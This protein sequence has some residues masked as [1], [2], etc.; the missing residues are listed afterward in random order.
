MNHEEPSPT[1]PVSPDI[2][3][4]FIAW[5]T[6]NPVAANLMMVVIFVGGLM[7]VRSVKQEVFPEFQLDLVAVSVAY[8]GASPAEVEQGIALA[9]EEAVR[10]VD[11]V[12]KV[13]STSSENVGTVIAELLV[14][15]DTK[16]ALADIKGEVD[17]IRTFPEEAEDPQVVLVS[18]RQRVI[19]LV[20]SGDLDL[21]ALQTLAESARA[22]LLGRG[23]VTQVEVQGLA[24]NE[25]A[26][27]IDL[28]TLQSYGLT[29]DDVAR[30]VG[31]ASLELPG[32][33]LESPAGE[34][35]VR[36]ADRRRTGEEFADIVVRGGRTGGEVRLGDIAT[37]RD[38]FEDAD[39]ATYFDGKPAVMLAA[40]RVGDETPTGV[41]D[42]VKSY[43]TDLRASVPSG[44]AVTVWDDD[45][46]LLRARI[47]LLVRNAQMGLVLVFVVLALFLELRLAFWVAWG[48]PTSFLG[49]FFLFPSQGVSINMISLFA[50]IIVLGIVVD[51]AIVVGENIYE[52]IERGMKPMQA[53]IA[54][55]VEMITPVTFS[56]LTTVA[57]FGPLLF[58]PGVSG[59][60]FGIIPIVVIS[61][62]LL[63][64]LESFF[65]LPR[66]LSHEAGAVFSFLARIT[67]PV[68]LRMSAAL[69][70]FA[71]GP[72]DRWVR[73]LVEYRYAT[74]GF[75]FG[76]V[77][78]ALGFVV[79]GVI[80]FS[81]L[82]KTEAD[83][84]RASVRLPFG[85][86]VSQT[87]RVREVL[88]GALS[89]TIQQ[90][91]AHDE[92]RGRLT[93]VG[94][95]AEGFGPAAASGAPTGSHLLTL[96]VDLVPVDQRNFTS[97]QF[98]AAWAAEVPALAGIEAIVFSSSA[99]PSG[100][101]AVDVQLSHA[102]TEVL[103]AASMEVAEA[104][105]GYDTLRSV[106]NSYA[107]GKVQLDLKLLDTSRSLGLTTQD[108]ARQVRSALFGAEAIREQRGRNEIKV[109]VRLPE[110]ERVSE[111]DLG[112]Y[113]V[114][115]PSGAWTPLSN[116]AEYDR[117]RSA[118][119]I[120]RDT[121]R[122]VV[123]ITADLAPGVKSSR[124][125]LEDL[126]ARVLPELRA[127][128]PGLGARFAGEAESQAETLGSLGQNYLF[129]LFVIFALVAIPFKSYAQPIIVMA[130][131]PFGFI[132]S[133]G[134][135][136]LH[137]YELSVISVMGII[138]ASGVV[139]NDS[140]VLVD[141]VNTFRAEG[142]GPLEAVVKA[143]KRRMRPILLTSL[144]TFFGLIPM[145]FETSVQARFLVPMAVA[146][147]YG[148]AFTTITALLA[149][150][151]LYMIVDDGAKLTAWL[152]GRGPAPWR[153]P[154]VEPGGDELI[155]K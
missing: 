24:P 112:R 148:V 110:A 136:L 78:I 49:A 42:A 50:L 151:C 86:P 155:A 9:V 89:R 90:F 133:I 23:G 107:A 2:L 13:T 79:S 52:K 58:V 45:S 96:E 7:Q 99:G 114:R 126:E 27:E 28:A 152:T 106:Q 104:L 138:A 111:F 46:E 81:F 142:L 63:S 61:V 116:V 80:P 145:I 141:A 8:P 135:H 140:I 117:S 21:M 134:G 34:V 43:V 26:I 147:A 11:G 132:G 48:I 128:Y 39:Q 144:T 35:L 131:I 55:T 127:K 51:D 38:G 149:V 16:K 101:A 103:A 115:T 146:L 67:D 84:V 77:F 118:T 150:P 154:E 47:D 88:E 15:A 85:V 108:I 113:E 12:K 120:A 121:G 105:H 87:E 41:S 5:M 25:I 40:Y 6:R 53:A 37:I 54:G 73:K 72:Y 119:S 56:V 97:A 122:R 18:R 10:G 124:P 102:D 130:A 31:F 75:L 109:M 69:E 30:Q 91:D 36:V 71:E 70:R 57:A 14:G 62:L 123:D 68:R 83:L 129:A 3:G 137:G 60:I 82:P 17:R 64:L 1:E 94:Q 143:G 93:K 44:V 95:G 33:A 74:T 76:L 29:L 98:E 65:I 4:S 66:H 100:G 59:K 20:V 153:A 22:E 139:V 32:G 125:V 19:N 92:V